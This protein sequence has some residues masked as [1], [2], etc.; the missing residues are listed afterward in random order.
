MGALNVSGPDL[1][2]R[3][4]ALI[5][6]LKGLPKGER[7]TAAI[8][9][10]ALD[11]AAA[12]PKE[13]PA[14]VRLRTALQAIGVKVR[15]WAKLVAL[16]RSEH[17]TAQQSEG[18]R[19]DA[20]PTIVVTERDEHEINETCVRALRGAPNVYQ[21]YGQLVR[22]VEAVRRR[23]GE[24]ST[25]AA[26]EIR[27]Y[28]PNLLRE[29]LSRHVCW[30]S[31]SDREDGGSRL[32]R[33]RCPDATPK[34]IVE[35]GRWPGVKEL[36]HL[37]QIPVLMPD[38]S[39][40]STPGFDERTGIYYDPGVDVPEVPEAPTQEDVQRA[41]AFLLDLVAQFPFE[42]D[43]H[44]SAWLASLLTPIARW[45]F[46]GQSPFFMLDANQ[47]GSGKGLLA[48][49]VSLIVLG[50]PMDL[51]T[52]TNNEEEE[53]KRITAK[54][55][56]GASCV[57]IDNIGSTFGSATL[58]A[59]LTTGVWSERLLGTNDAPNLDTHIVWYGSGNNVQYARD[60][61]RRRVCNIRLMTQEERP[62]ERK[63]FTH[64]DLEGHVARYRGLY[65]AAAL[66]VLRG[67]MLAKKKASSLPGW[68]GPWGSFNG[69]DQ[70]VRGA[71]LFAGLPD[72]IETKAT[73][74]AVE[75]EAEGLDKL[76]DGVA[77][78]ST[79]LSGGRGAR[80][81]AILEAMSENDE[82]RKKSKDVPVRFKALREAIAKL[83]PRLRLGELP[84]EQQLGRLFGKFKDKPRGGRR[85]G[86]KTVDGYVHWVV[87]QVQAAA[88]TDAAPAPCTPT[89]PD[90]EKVSCPRAG[91]TCAPCG[92]CGRCRR[93]RGEDGCLAC[94]I[95][96][97][98]TVLAPKDGGCCC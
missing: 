46:S 64:E 36:H 23:A 3:I 12:I 5:D 21:R 84:S 62:E 82:W 88:P 20:R 11:I 37:S 9:D 50:R 66:T 95:C 44:K 35:W 51:M 24:E 57:L 61:I 43:A 34:A 30:R 28:S 25:Y 71:V 85:L 42:T 69:W 38:G 96:G 40:V 65:L 98:C 93:S 14:L 67:W 47:A 48:R 97:E 2:E 33:A 53:R 4:T 15:E 87:D 17:V 16:R 77:D 29:E 73:R 45:A 54:I 31:R 52:A 26:K 83:I 41:A 55:I 7:T 76:L 79:Q 70:V 81:S 86:V 78:A 39:L 72:P 1:V 56:G 75:G 68:G 19:A 59:L 91:C 90:V 89:R 22:I 8:E 63:G 74:G 92:K 58:E 18:E 94:K 60:D 80:T 6:R 32:V 10:D 49:V 13:S 27:T